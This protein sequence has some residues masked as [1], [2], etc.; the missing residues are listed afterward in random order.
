M[1]ASGGDDKIMFATYLRDSFTGLDYADQRFYASS[2]GRFN[3]ADPYAG[4]AGPSDPGSWNR[5]AYTRG[6]PIN[7][8]DPLVL[9]TAGRI[10]RPTLH[11]AGRVWSMG[12]PLS[13]SGAVVQSACDQ[14][15]MAYGSAPVTYIPC[16]YYAPI[17]LVATPSVPHCNQLS[18]NAFSLDYSQLLYKKGTQSTQDHIIERHGEGITGNPT[19]GVSQYYAF[20]FLQIENLNAA[21]FL[22][23]SRS[24]TPVRDTINFSWTAPQLTPEGITS[25]RTLAE[26]RLPRIYWSS[27][28]TARPSS[29]LIQFRES[30]E[31]LER[32]TI[33]AMLC[34][35]TVLGVLWEGTQLRAQRSLPLGEVRIV[36]AGKVSPEERV[37]IWA[38][39]DIY[40]ALGMTS[41]MFSD[42]EDRYGMDSL[43]VGDGGELLIPGFPVFSRKWPGH[44]LIRL[45]SLIQRRPSW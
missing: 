17:I 42:W 39:G 4:S 10:G 43:G 7:R 15:V 18:L 41:K 3:S 26:P 19:P 6:D 36:R 35:G 14:L 8:G 24:S 44:T 28:P 1:N 21:T 9:P 27:S 37:Q 31:V 16:N 30:I 5:Y 32:I 13:I 25:G 23:G 45:I 33:F 2:Y 20:F 34:L 11:S 40:T 38:Y 22:F 29:H 12:M